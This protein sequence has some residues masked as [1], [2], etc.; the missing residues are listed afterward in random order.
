MEEEERG[1][2]KKN[3]KRKEK[4][5]LTYL[6]WN[7]GGSLRSNPQFFAAFF[8]QLLFRCRPIFFLHRITSRTGPSPLSRGLGPIIYTLPCNTLATWYTSIFYAVFDL[9]RGVPPDLVLGFLHFY[10]IANPALLSSQPGI[11]IACSFDRLLPIPSCQPNARAIPVCKKGQR[12]LP[13]TLCPLLNLPQGLRL[14][15]LSSESDTISAFPPFYIRVVREL[16]PAGSHSSC[17][18]PR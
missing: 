1:V 10:C 4:K 11:I 7:F 13:T 6:G 8:F 14:E 15:V 16:Q 9:R 2:V 5:I 3:L 18:S 12:L 17:I